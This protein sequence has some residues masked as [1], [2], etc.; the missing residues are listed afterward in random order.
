VPALALLPGSA[1]F[2]HRVDGLHQLPTQPPA[3]EIVLFV[4]SLLKRY[5]DLTEVGPDDNT[6]WADGR[7]LNDAN[8]GFIDFSV[9]WDYYD[10]VAPFIVT[11]AHKHGLNCYDRQIY[12]YYPFRD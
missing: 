6:A 7:M 3:T 10:K 12:R 2:L 1:G 5:P 11:T 9:R 8:G 4:G